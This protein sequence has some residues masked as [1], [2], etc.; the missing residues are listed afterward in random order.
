[1]RG[2]NDLRTQ[3]QQLASRM[4][5]SHFSSQFIRYGHLNQFEHTAETM[6]SQ[7]LLF[8]KQPK[9]KPMNEPWNWNLILNS[10]IKKK[11]PRVSRQSW[12][13]FRK[14]HKR[15]KRKRGRRWLILKPW[16]MICNKVYIINRFVV[17]FSLSPRVCW[18]HWSVDTFL[19][20]QKM[21]QVCGLLLIHRTT[22]SN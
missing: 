11:T 17:F 12:Q 4:F 10:K 8:Q 14:F 16:M 15:E 7:I 20:E 3:Q 18:E 21:L 6:C 1:M 19:M 9:N 13:K 2:K 22:N 5:A